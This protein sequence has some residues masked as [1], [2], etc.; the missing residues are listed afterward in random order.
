MV[1]AKPR[2]DWDFSC[3]ESQPFTHNGTVESQGTFPL[4]KKKKKVY[5]FSFD[6]TIA[7]VANVFGRTVKLLKDCAV[8]AAFCWFSIS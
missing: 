2:T 6:R 7:R 8:G 1:V 5:F 4:R 3:P